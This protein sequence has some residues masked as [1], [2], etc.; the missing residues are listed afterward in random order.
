MNNGLHDNAVIRYTTQHDL[1]CSWCGYRI[2]TR[3][4][5]RN[6]ERLLEWSSADVMGFFCSE[7]HAIAA[8]NNVQWREL[9]S[10]KVGA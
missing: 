10:F 2:P 5:S 6:T 7:S 1:A 3:K 4:T 8:T 9:Y